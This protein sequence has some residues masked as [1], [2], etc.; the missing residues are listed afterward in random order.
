M[1]LQRFF[2]RVIVIRQNFSSVMNAILRKTLKYLLWLSLNV[3]VI[4]F[5]ILFLAVVN[6]VNKLP[7]ITELL[8]D[9]KR[10]SVTLLDI[11]ENVFAW[12]GNQFGGVLKAK[13]L[14]RVLH[15]A[16][17]SVEDRTFYSHYG[18]SIRGILGAIRINLREGRGPLWGVLRSRGGGS[19]GGRGGQAVGTSAGAL[20]PAFYG[21]H[22]SS[23]GDCTGC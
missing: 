2:H 12:R 4:V 16:I 10:G 5:V 13:S 15:D 14:N 3:A 17:I 20:G 21:H 6:Y 23:W 7:P 9:R 11:N 8:D 19:R 18:V 1:G 22:S